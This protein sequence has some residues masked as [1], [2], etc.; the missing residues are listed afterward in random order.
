MWWLLPLWL[1]VVLGLLG[2]FLGVAYYF[3]TSDF[4]HWKKKG[5]KYAKAVPFFGSLVRSMTLQDH[6][7]NDLDRI[8][9]DFQGENFVGFFQGRTA[10][11]LVRDPELIKEILVKDFSH[12]YNHGFKIH[13]EADPMQAKSLFNL[14]DHKWKEMRSKLSPTFTSGKIKMMTP[15]M[16][17]VSQNFIAHLD[18]IS[19]SGKPFETKDLVSRFTTDIISS[20]AFGVKSNAIDDPNTEFRVMGRKLVEMDFFKALKTFV[21]LFLP[22]V[23]MSLRLAFTEKVVADFFR[24]LVHDV[25]EVRKKT[26]LVRKDFMHLLIELKDKGSIAS[27]G[28]EDEKEIKELNGFGTTISTNTIKLTHDDLTAQ[29]SIFFFAGFETSSTLISFASLELSV[30]KEAQKKLQADI[31]QALKNHGGKLCYDALKDMK[32]LDAVVQE[33][34]RKYPPAVNIMRICTKNYIIPGTK[35]QIDEG[36][37]LIIPAFSLQ[38]DPKYFP[39][40]EMFDPERFMDEDALHKYQYLHMPFGEGPRMCIGN[41]FALVQSKMGIASIFS[42]FDVSIAS[43]TKYPPTFDKQL[44]ILAAE[45]GIWLNVNPRRE[46]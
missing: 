38:N 35:V 19:K 34:L 20:C 29:A 3:L 44:F 13:E 45:G 42:K 1:N 22:E 17:E 30:N 15:L 21:I 33:T 26:N 24:K 40:P 27:E 25:M 36:T 37:P 2:T 6:L 12:F 4:D 31:D 10:S 11:I 41:R 28:A 14:N 16:E 7:V 9:K 43:K 18:K 32:Y 46:E 5:V 39:N 8:Y 23:G